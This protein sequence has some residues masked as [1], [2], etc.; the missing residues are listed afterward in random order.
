[1]FS[2]PTAQGGRGIPTATTSP[3][4]LTGRLMAVRTRWTSVHSAVR[5][6]LAAAEPG[7]GQRGLQIGL[8]LLWLLDAALQYQPFMFGPGFV[9]SGIEPATAGNPAALVSSVTW[10][11]QMMLRHIAVYNALFASIQL[12]LAIGFFFRRTVKLALAAS[13]A[14]ALSVWWFG[15]SLGGILTGSSPLAG[16][17]GAVVLYVLIAIL[18]WPP[19]S[20]AH[21]TASA[22]AAG[23]FGAAGANLLWLA[24]WG[25]FAHYLLLP[26]NRASDAI[27]HV[28]SAAD[29]QP[30]WVAATTTMLAHAAEHRGGQISV[31]L[32]VACAG[33]ALGVFSRRARRPVLVIAAGLGLLF[34]IAEGFGGI[35][36]G[37]G[38]DPNTGPLLILLAACYWPARAS[39]GS[40][41]PVSHPAPFRKS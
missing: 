40:A 21:Q 2:A 1:V 15:E 32:A 41:V 31:V 11:S 33:V 29:G 37:Q 34:W 26:A 16:L 22:A 36:T 18:L 12:L 38:T 20:H 9:T 3:T 8:G 17:P 4:L 6:A 14:W 13:I 30:K 10:A 19:R 24:L 39:R 25:G 27:T 35:F 23:P 28:L 7:P 5:S